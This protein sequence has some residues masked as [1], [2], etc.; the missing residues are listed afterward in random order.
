[1]A[2]S[3]TDLG[4]VG[5]V[6]GRPP[7]V[8]STKYQSP[9]PPKASIPSAINLG[10]WG[11]AIQRVGQ[12]IEGAKS[13]EGFDKSRTTSARITFKPSWALGLRPGGEWTKSGMMQVQYHDIKDGET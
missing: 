8:S 7:G 3:T 5:Q 9:P 1:M 13:I 10:G 11:Y 4:A 6:D 12:A 2:S